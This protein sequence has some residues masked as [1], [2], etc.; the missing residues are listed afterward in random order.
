LLNKPF[1]S[2]ARYFPYI[3]FSQGSVKYIWR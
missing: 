2:D 1:V 3:Y